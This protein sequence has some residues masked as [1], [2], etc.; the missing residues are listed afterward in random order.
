[1][2][3]SEESTMNIKHLTSAG[4]LVALVSMP[5]ACSS[6]EGSRDG[7]LNG[8]KG[9]NGN[10]GAGGSLDGTG[11]DVDID[12]GT[13]GDKGT[14]SDNPKTCADAEAS[15]S[16]VGCDFWPTVTANPVYREFLPAV[17]VANGGDEASEVKV[18]GPNGFSKTE[19]VPPGE[20]RTIM[21]AWVE[22]LKGPEWPANTTSTARLT[23]SSRVDGG[24]FHMTATKP[25]TAWQFNPLKYTLPK[26]ECGHIELP[27]DATGCRSASNDASILLPS[28]AMTGNY[29]V[30]GYSSRHEGKDWGTVPGGVAITATQDATEVKVQLAE[31]CGI[32]LYPTTDLGT[33]VSASLDDAIPAKDGGELY[34]FTMNAGD[35]V[36]LVGQ[37]NLDTNAQV[38]N[39][40]ISGSI[41]NANKPVQAIA[42]N[43]IAMLPDGSVGNAD[44]MEE[45]ILPGEVLG[46]KYVVVPP[47]APHG[48]VVGHV[49]R[50]YGNVDGTHLTYPEGKPAGAPDTLNAGDMVQIPALPVGLPPAQCIGVE[51]KCALNE[52]F[53]VEGDQPF[54]VASFMLGGVVQE[55]KGYDSLGD[56]S[57]MMLVTPEQFR[58]KYTFLAPADFVENYADIL[59]P[60][61][62]SATLDGTALPAGTPIGASGWSIVRAP[63]GNANDGIHHLETADE[64]GLGLSVAGF[65]YATSYYYPGGLNLKLISDPPVIII[66]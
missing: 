8:G 19:T 5:L 14:P 16:Y 44:H 33:C 13:G 39:A 41:I 20:L 37:W 17:V 25:V 24:A 11:G 18:T 7:G 47:T 34:T 57:F 49:V 38:P 55:N 28:T 45:T 6:D 23:Y 12:G 36:Q 58:T 46:K 2:R 31:K 1:M 53:V 42:F 22:G 3:S 43:A 29:R 32:V 51:G 10:N 26:A 54:A 59:V 56:P 4:L 30:F 15:R 64:R 66:K 65:G 40:D 62:A 63:L 9:G 35:V 61:G 27:A 21:L 60:E 52:P 50:L 48:A